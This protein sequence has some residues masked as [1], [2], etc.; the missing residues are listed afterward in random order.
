MVGDIVSINTLLGGSWL[1][2]IWVFSVIIF[3][4]P[5]S[6]IIVILNVAYSSIVRLDGTCCDIRNPLL[7]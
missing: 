2:V 5:F 1:E 7:F 6:S 3:G 4:N